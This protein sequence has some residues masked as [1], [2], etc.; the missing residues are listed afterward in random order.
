TVAPDVVH[1][2]LAGRSLLE[3]LQWTL[4]PRQRAT[5]LLVGH[6]LLD[7]VA[8]T[9]THR[10]PCPE[11][12]LVLDTG[13]ADRK[14]IR[15]TLRLLDGRLGTLHRDSFKET[16]RDSSSFEFEVNTAPDPGVRQIPPP[17][18]HP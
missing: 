10:I 2:V 15:A 8:R 7:R 11:R 3:D 4:P 9:G 1:A 16:E 18:F 17:A 14:T 6:A 12:D 13:I 5:L